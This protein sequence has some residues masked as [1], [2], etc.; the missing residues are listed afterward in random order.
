MK[1]VAEKLSSELKEAIF[2]AEHFFEELEIILLQNE[3]GIVDEV[4]RSK[5]TPI[6]T[7]E[8]L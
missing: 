7:P 1:D 6:K 5:S 8:L 2:F 4:K 3:S